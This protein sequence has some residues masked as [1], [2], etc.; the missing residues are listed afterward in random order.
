MRVLQL[1]VTLIA[2][3]LTPVLAKAQ[4]EIT[5]TS[6][7][8]NG[9]LSWTNSVSSINTF[10]VEWAPSAGGPWTNDWS[11]LR[12][13]INTQSLYSVAVP[14][15]YRVIGKPRSIYGQ[16]VHEGQPLTNI[17]VRLLLTSD[18]PSNYVLRAFS[19]DLGQYSFTNLVPDQTYW[20]YVNDPAGQDGS[21]SGF[22]MVR[23]AEMPFNV[24]VGMNIV[25][26]HP[27]NN[28]NVGPSPLF[29]WVG[30]PGAATYTVNLFG[31]G[32]DVNTIIESASNITATTYQTL[33]SLPPGWYSWQVWAYDE[34]G[35]DT[36]HSL[37][38][39]D[40]FNVVN[41]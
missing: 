17:E 3:F 29:Q 13:I 22:E 40:W 6:F 30:I 41:P 4:G 20:L 19:D 1:Y 9:V 7:D 28:E 31:T 32:A 25:A 2:G 23:T 8:R 27:I 35:W 36:G 33:L 34:W 18:Y 14:M 5:I 38:S 15:F 26:L 39:R 37:P 12:N 16:V 21:W 24:G 10:T 11:S